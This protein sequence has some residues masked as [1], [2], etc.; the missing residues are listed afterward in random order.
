VRPPPGGRRAAAALIVALGGGQALAGV[1]VVLPAGKPAPPAPTA[2]RARLVLV[3]ERG[4]WDEAFSVDEAGSRVAVVRTDGDRLL[5]AEIYDLAPSARWPPGAGAGASAAGGSPGAAGSGGGGANG[6]RAG[7]SAAE[8]TQAFD[9]PAPPRAFESL[10]F[11]PDGQGLALV[12]VAEDGDSRTLETIDLGGRRLGRAGPVWALGFTG[13]GGAKVAVAVARKVGTKGERRYTVTPLGLPALRPASKPRS[14][15]VDRGGTLAAPVVVPQGFFDSYTKVLALRPGAYDRKKDARQPDSR[16]VLDLLT[17]RAV[18]ESPIEDVH[19]W[20]RTT[21]LRSE[22]T[23][24]TVFLQFTEDQGTLQLVDGDGRLAPV[25]LA[26]PLELYDVHS[27]IEQ[28]EPGPAPGRLHFSLQVDP[29]NRDAVAR[30][31]ADEPFLDVYT[32]EPGRPAETRLRARVPIDRRPVSWKVV[33]TGDGDKLL[34]L[35]RF[36]SFS[37]GGD[38]LEIYDL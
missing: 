31:R 10:R 23:G 38:R 7:G 37:R 34:V 14:Y 16:L 24:R 12:E 32:M 8:P 1:E 36:K 18:A 3:P 35:R 19:G 25:S 11:L 28:E 20:V 22:H 17:G 13:A 29:V 2:S 9:L 4:F 27:L 30:Q 15:A 21:R 6:A 26:V 5:R 33:A